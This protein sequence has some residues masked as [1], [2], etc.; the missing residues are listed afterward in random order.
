MPPVNVILQ[1]TRK[2]Y[3]LVTIK[4]VLLATDVWSLA[5]LQSIE[6]LG[7]QLANWNPD[8]KKRLL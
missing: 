2:F 4:P 1:K 8:Y 6:G 5:D 7:G 3:I